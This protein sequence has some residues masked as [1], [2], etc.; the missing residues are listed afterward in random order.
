MVILIILA[1]I[2]VI[3]VSVL[4]YKYIKINPKSNLIFLD[5]N[6]TTSFLNKSSTYKQSFTNEDIRRRSTFQLPVEWTLSEQHTILNSYNQLNATET[7]TI[8]KCPSNL[9]WNYPH[10]HK[11][12]IFLPS[13]YMSDAKTLHHE[14]IHIMQRRYPQ[15]FRNLYIDWQFTPIDSSIIPSNIIAQVR[16]NPDLFGEIERWWIWRNRWIPLAMWS[17]KNGNAVKIMV[18]DIKE[19]KLVNPELTPYYDYFRG[20]HDAEHPNEIAAYMISD[21]KN[22]DNTPSGLILNQHLNH[23]GN[24]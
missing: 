22:F 12:I 8:A 16:A 17:E 18:Y 23:V 21:I 9:D 13:T 10:T 19:N 6:A 2:L 5:A 24:V 3:V 4:I 20:V 11:D 15:R 1:I 14:M 7:F